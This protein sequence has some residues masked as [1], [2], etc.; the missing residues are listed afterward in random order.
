[1]FFSW[2]NKT[3]NQISGLRSQI[4]DIHNNVQDSFSKVRTDTQ[5]LFNWVNFFYERVE[6]VESQMDKMSY[7]VAS[8]V[9]KTEM[10]QMVDYYYAE[11]QAKSETLQK[12]LAVM[13]NE[14]Q[15]LRN[16][17]NMDFQGMV[18]NQKSIFEKIALLS[19]RIDAAESST[20]H[21]REV[22]L[23]KE[24]FEERMAT[25]SDKL[26]SF[27]EKIDAYDE[28]M[29]TFDERIERLREIASAGLEKHRKT[30]SLHEKTEALHQK[31]DVLHHKTNILHEKTDAIHSKTDHL[32]KRIEVLESQKPKT[33][34]EKILTKISR[35]SKEYMKGMILSL[36]KKYDKISAL[37]LREMLVE[38]QGL[39]SKSS[40]Y[41]LLEEIEKSDEVSMVVEGKEKVFQYHYPSPRKD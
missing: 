1:M 27:N 13:R 39:L 11:Q 7:D 28:R 30:D 41:R 17:L 36:I 23:E 34:K 21:E 10:R 20:L 16:S 5:Q 2:R 25:V 37:Q 29:A 40:F 31:T 19:S 18:T 8:L 32:I 35:R 33:T 12:D 38:E 26:D 14:V 15:S 24:A 6:I 3:E 4:N 9:T 22:F